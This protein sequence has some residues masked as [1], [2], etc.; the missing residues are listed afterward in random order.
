MRALFALLLG[1]WTVEMF[2]LGLFLLALG[3][4]SRRGMDE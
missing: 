2:T 1:I 4:R 3:V